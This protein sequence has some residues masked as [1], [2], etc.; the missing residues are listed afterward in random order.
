MKVTVN[1]QLLATEL[2][3]VLKAVP[4]KP[5]IQILGC[6]LLVAKGEDLK[7]AATNLEL[8]LSSRC[9]ATV[10]ED[11]AIV[12]PAAKFLAL[13]ERFPDDDVEL[14]EDQGK[15][16]VRCGDF[17][18]QIVAHKAVDYPLLPV[19]RGERSTIDGNTLAALINKVSAAIDPTS[20]KQV[21]RGALL[22]LQGP[23][24]AM[25]AT[26]GKRLSVAT[27]VREGGTDTRVIVHRV[28]MDAIASQAGT[29][30][31]STTNDHLFFRYGDR[32]ISS[33]VI[34]GDYPPYE[35]IIPKANK[36][37]VT[38][39]S[40]AMAAALHRMSVV[41]EDN[42]ATKFSLST[43]QLVLKSSSA[44][45][46]VAEE[47]VA[48]KYAGPNLDGTVSGRFILDFLETSTSSSI[49]LKIKDGKSAM[50]FEDGDEAVTVI[51]PMR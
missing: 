32:L 23:A 4:G 27:A 48:V 31:F 30:E 39:E 13:V 7:V 38:F 17:T 10:E 22:M 6:V 29:V 37:V 15:T 45:V 8:T 20:S 44:E 21:L 9:D 43:N 16:L 36:L 40:H 34:D 24:V 33:V 25:V 1:S 3:F 41:A 26:D 35:R 51:M 14:F 47:K 12:L 42:G 11:G 2:R 49:V 18:S 46:G 19:E 50:L 28:A 5:A